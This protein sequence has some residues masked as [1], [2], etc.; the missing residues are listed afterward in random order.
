MVQVANKLGTGWRSWAQNRP[1]RSGK[2]KKDSLLIKS[3]KLRETG[4]K[5]IHQT[6]GPHRLDLGEKKS[7]QTPA[8]KFTQQSSTGVFRN[9]GKNHGRC[10]APVRLGNSMSLRTPHQ[11]KHAGKKGVYNKHSV[12]NRQHVK[13]R[14]IKKVLKVT[15][16]TPASKNRIESS[17]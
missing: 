10:G 8:A 12:P 5:K 3:S 13:M 1:R 9:G 15:W 4:K 7:Q 17:W 6:R 14:E 16:R 11:G 2:T